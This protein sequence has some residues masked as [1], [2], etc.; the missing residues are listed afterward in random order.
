MAGREIYDF[1]EYS[2]SKNEYIFEIPDN[3][4][5]RNIFIHA[6][7]FNKEGKEVLQKSIDLGKLENCLSHM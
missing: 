4:L 3:L 5:E 7:L 2:S 6:I 1:V